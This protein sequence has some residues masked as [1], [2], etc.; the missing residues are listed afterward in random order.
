[1]ISPEFSGFNTNFKYI[2]TVASTQRSAASGPIEGTP[3]IFWTSGTGWKSPPSRSGTALVLVR[4]DSLA[5]AANRQQKDATRFRFGSD[6]HRSS[7][8]GG[9]RMRSRRARPRKKGGRSPLW[10]RVFR[11]VYW[12]HALTVSMLLLTHSSATSSGSILSRP[13]CRIHSLTTAGSSSIWLR[14]F[15]TGGL[16]V[17]SDFEYAT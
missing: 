14:N 15:A 16:R 4:L 7:G 9:H 6:Q 1:M 11:Q 8:H 13:I 10:L 5:L 17:S 2:G 3:R 12:I